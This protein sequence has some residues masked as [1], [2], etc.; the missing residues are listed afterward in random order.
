MNEIKVHLVGLSRVYFNR[1]VGEDIVQSE[2]SS[3]LP[4]DVWKES[5]S[6]I[7]KGQ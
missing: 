1:G 2:T 7:F 3:W 6:F 4:P 5:I